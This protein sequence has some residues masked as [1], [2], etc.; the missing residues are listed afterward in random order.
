MHTNELMA[1]VGCSYPTAASALEEF[2]E[3]VAR[4]SDRRIELSRWPRLPWLRYIGA[5]EKARDTERYIDRSGSPRAATDLIRRLQRL[6]RRDVAIGGTLGALHHVPSLDVVGTP[7]LA[8][9]LHD[10]H[11]RASSAFVEHLDPALARTESRDETPLVV[12][13]RQR[14]VEFLA[15]EDES[16][17]LW[18][19]PV[20]CLLDLHEAGVEGLAEQFWSAIVSRRTKG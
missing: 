13:H 3:D 19:D 18:A 10:P 4:G 5:Q 6:K 9:T 2:K 1:S 20:E 7:T 12:V 8:L 14:L 11:D 16:G 15:T 17:T